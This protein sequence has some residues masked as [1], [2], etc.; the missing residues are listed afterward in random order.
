VR[1][2]RIGMGREILIFNNFPEI[3]IGGRRRNEVKAG[4]D[5]ASAALKR[6]GEEVN[7]WRKSP[8]NQTLP[9]SYRSGMTIHGIQARKK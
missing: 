5:A 8:S 9:L 4:R 3:I 2:V 7:S 6:A 1:F